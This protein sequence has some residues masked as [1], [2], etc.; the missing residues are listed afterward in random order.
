ME[1]TTLFS[2]FLDFITEEF[3]VIKEVKVWCGLK[4]KVALFLLWGVQIFFT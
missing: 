1:G 4:T 2:G 3:I